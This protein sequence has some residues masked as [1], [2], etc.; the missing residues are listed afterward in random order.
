[1]AKG[2]AYDNIFGLGRYK[3]MKAKAY[4]VINGQP[5]LTVNVVPRAKRATVSPPDSP[6]TPRA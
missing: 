1:M 4:Q 2:V 6:I 3:L 5:F